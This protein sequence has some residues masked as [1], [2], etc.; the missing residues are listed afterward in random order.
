MFMAFEL[1]IMLYRGVFETVQRL[2]DRVHFFGE[3]EMISI[4]SI[5]V[6][7]AGIIDHIIWAILYGLY[8]FI[9]NL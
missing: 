2:S 9:I 3:S 6:R 5:W 4:G 8:I 7:F 1:S